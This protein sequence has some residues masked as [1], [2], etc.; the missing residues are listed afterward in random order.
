MAYEK[1]SCLYDTLKDLSDRLNGTIIR[2][3]GVP[4]H[5]TVKGD[6]R[7]HLTD[8][9]NA[10][11][12]SG[13]LGAVSPKDP[14]LDISSIEIGY[15]NWD[16]S[17]ESRRYLTVSQQRGEGNKVSYL[18]RLPIQRYRQGLT[19]DVVRTLG[20]DGESNK[21]S[22]ESSME[23]FNEGFKNMVAGNYPTYPEAAQL[24]FDGEEKEIAISIDFALKATDSSLI[25]VY[26]QTRNIGW[27][28]PNK[29]LIKIPDD[30]LEWVYRR[31]MRQLRNI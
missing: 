23:L 31:L 25:L 28:E 1:M 27:I 30:E 17:K 21:Y 13:N 18:Q 2:Y 7:L 29:G 4:V 16:W 5:V 12:M 10:N 3:K 22:S 6:G 24:L 15:M 9:A 14:D 8:V 26:Y 19:S 11:S 20:V